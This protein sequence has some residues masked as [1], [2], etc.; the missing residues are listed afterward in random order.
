MAGIISSAVVRKMVLRPPAIRMKNE[1]GILSVAPARPAMAV[2][3]NSSSG[4]NGKPRFSICT[5][6]MPHISQT[7][8]PIRR[9]GMEIHRLRLAIFLP[10]DSQN[11]WSSTS[12]SL[13]LIDISQTSLG[14]LK[15]LLIP[16]YPVLGDFYGAPGLAA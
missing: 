12:H 16:A 2:R 5:V 6:M 13:M 15:V 14:Y 4:L 3:V 11:F 10:V 7:A 8:K 9:L 1:A